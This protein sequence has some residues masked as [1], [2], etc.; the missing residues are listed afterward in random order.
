MSDVPLRTRQQH[1]QGERTRA[2]LIGVAQ[3]A[4]ATTPD[5]AL[6]SIAKSAGVG[7]GTLYRHFPTREALI[8]E[9]YRRE[10]MELADAAPDLLAEH[11]PFEALRL[12]LEHFARHALTKAGFVDALRSATSH[13][14]LASEAYEPVSAAVRLLVEANEAA[15]TIRS[16]VTP[17][18]LYLAVGGLYQIDPTSDW[19][20]RVRWLLDLVLAGMRSPG[21]YASPTWP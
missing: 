5:V 4:F 18:D 14:Q 9:V 7:I 19:E 8:L 21:H 2:Y 20:P 16:G 3:Q 10:V 15:S 12:W 13:G 1:E 17:D 11:P 6:S